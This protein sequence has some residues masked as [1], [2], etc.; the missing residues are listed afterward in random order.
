MEGLC[1]SQGEAVVGGLCTSQGGAVEEAV[2]K[3]REALS[4]S[5]LGLLLPPD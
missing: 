4:L 2:H 1:T 3:T 5:S